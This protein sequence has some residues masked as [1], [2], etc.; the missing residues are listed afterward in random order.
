MDLV[1]YQ[2]QIEA[3]KRAL[4]LKKRII[5]AFYIGFYGSHPNPVPAILAD[6]NHYNAQCAGYHLGPQDLQKVQTNKALNY[7]EDFKNTLNI[8][9]NNV[10]DAVG[11]DFTQD[12]ETDIKTFE[13]IR[14]NGNTILK[15]LREDLEK[16]PTLWLQVVEKNIALSQ[17]LIGEGKYVTANQLLNDEMNRLFKAEKTSELKP[18]RV[19]I[20]EKIGQIFQLNREIC[21]KNFFAGENLN[22]NFAMGLQKLERYCLD[23]YTGRE[24]INP[25]RDGFS[26]EQKLT[27]VLACI[28]DLVMKGTLTD[29][30]LSLPATD[31]SRLGA[32]V[33]E[34]CELFKITRPSIATTKLCL[35]NPTTTVLG[36]KSLSSSASSGIPAIPNIAPVF[37]FF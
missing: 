8:F 15:T 33:D 16:K 14:D 22:Y 28:N 37:S 2:Q 36:G 12:N 7:L 23:R 4:D 6:I 30:T 17:D 34:I 21:K 25:F 32:S 9:S 27:A 5:M 3:R 35:S 19:A 10:K 18:S 31:D 20:K 24:Y 13:V 11:K 26:R 29:E 1:Q